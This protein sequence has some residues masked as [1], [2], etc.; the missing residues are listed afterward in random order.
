[1][2][3]GRG[4]SRVGAAPAGKT[5]LP[6][7]LGC[8][9]LELPV[10]I[11]ATTRNRWNRR[12]LRRVSFGRRLIARLCSVRFLGARRAWSSGQHLHCS[13]RVRHL[14]FLTLLAWNPVLS[15][16]SVR[17]GSPLLRRVCHGW[18]F[19]NFFPGW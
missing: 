2:D 8:T 9:C 11:F 7:L 10:R 16:R 13:G 12:R 4:S 3:C 1:M 19:Y 14:A 15:L 5:L 17:S 6:L 18:L